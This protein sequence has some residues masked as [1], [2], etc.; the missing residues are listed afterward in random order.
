MVA[1]YRDD[2]GVAFATGENRH[3]QEEYCEWRVARNAAGKIT[4]VIF[5]TETPE[6]WEQL[7]AVAPARVVSLY[8]ALVSPAVAEA[9]LAGCWPR[10]RV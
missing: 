4:K 5:V 9:E 7:W 3:V 2:R 1:T 8:Q 10:Q 6:Y